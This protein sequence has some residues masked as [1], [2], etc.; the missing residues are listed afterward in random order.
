MQFKKWA[1]LSVALIVIAFAGFAASTANAIINTIADNPVPSCPSGFVFNK[2]TAS[3]D[4]I[5]V[6]NVTAVLAGKTVSASDVASGKITIL[7]DD[8]VKGGL[9][10]VQIHSPRCHWTNGPWGNSFIDGNGH[11]VWYTETVPGYLCPSK[12]SPT[13]LVKVK[14]GKTGRH[15]LNPA[16]EGMQ[17]PGPVVTGTV[18]SF[19]SF[20]HVTIPLKAAVAVEVHD[21]CG[22]AQASA[23][24]AATISLSAFVRAKGNVSADTF[25]QVIASLSTS[26][27]ANINCAPPTTVTTTTPAP[28]PSTTTTNT[29]TTVVT[30]TTPSPCTPAADRNQY[31]NCV[32]PCPPSESRFTRSAQSG[33]YGFVAKGDGSFYSVYYNDT[34]NGFWGQSNQIPNGAVSG[35]AACYKPAPTG[36]GPGGPP[37]SP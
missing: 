3:C 17:M 12:A 31:N 37:P 22:S 20:A 21:T 23:T 28:P 7:A 8:T 5:T 35:N 36:T 32:S 9:K 24:A 1:T 15:C 25:G 10:A 6:S 16:K 30:T 4:K 27:K 29:T 26:A 34:G 33:G 11:R 19:R 14:G 13:G 2:S 18:I